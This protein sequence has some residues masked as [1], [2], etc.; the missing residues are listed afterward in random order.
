MGSIALAD[1]LT[2]GF[3]SWTYADLGLVA[4]LSARLTVLGS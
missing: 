1:S 3:F 2:S 4:E